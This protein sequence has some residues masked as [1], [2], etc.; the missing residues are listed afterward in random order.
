[1]NVV[2]VRA[3]AS[4]LAGSY[5][6]LAGC[7]SA[8]LFGYV[9]PTTYNFSLSVQMLFGLVIGGNE[10]AGRRADR[11]LFLEFFPSLVASLGKGLS[12]LLYAVLLIVAIVAMP[13]GIAGALQRS[14]GSRASCALMSGL[15][16]RGPKDQLPLNTGARFSTKA[17]GGFLVILSLAVCGSGATLRYP[18]PRR[19]CLPQ[20][21][22]CSV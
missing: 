2:H 15:E 17:R 16:A 3:V 5:L 8:F 7:L 12:A 21:P 18:A 9:G 1:M 19:A 20:R 10:F 6:A 14:C 13:T 11:R 4:G 22:S